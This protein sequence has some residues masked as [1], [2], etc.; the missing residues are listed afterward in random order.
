MSSLRSEIVESQKVRSELLKWKLVIVSVL[1]GTGLGFI[2][3]DGSGAGAYLL[4][5]LIPGVCFYV[6]LLCRHITLRIKVIGSFYRVLGCGEDSAYEEFVPQT[7]ELGPDKVNPFQL[8]DWALEYSTYALSAM[9]ALAG[10]VLIFWPCIFARIT[11]PYLVGVAFALSGLLGIILT[12]LIK[13]RYKT[14]FQG[15][16]DFGKDHDPKL[17][18]R[19]RE[20]R[21]RT[22]PAHPSGAQE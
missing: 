5:L 8:E 3:T 6:D 1:G 22:A 17:R 12:L 15:L 16:T 18:K 10:A 4:L 7:Y 14:A 9:V 2:N 11:H 19:L 20:I 21:D 13:V